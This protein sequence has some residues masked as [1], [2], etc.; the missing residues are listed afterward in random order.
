MDVL[1]ILD[2]IDRLEDAIQTIRADIKATPRDGDLSSEMNSY[3]HKG[4]AEFPVSKGII[5]AW[6]FRVGQLEADLTSRDKY[7]HELEADCSWQRQKSD[8]A[9][10]ALKAGGE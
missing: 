4:F 8:A 3:T 2:G 7:I 1:R 5:S 9:I 6:S 10:T